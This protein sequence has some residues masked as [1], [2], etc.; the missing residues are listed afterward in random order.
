MCMCRSVCMWVQV[1]GSQ[2][3]L[4]QELRRAIVSSLAWGLGTDLQE[5]QA[6]P[7]LHTPF[8]FSLLLS[9]QSHRIT[10]RLWRYSPSQVWSDTVG[11]YLGVFWREWWT[12]V[13]IHLGEVERN[14]CVLGREGKLEEPW[15]KGVRHWGG[16][17]GDL[18]I[19]GCNLTK[20]RG[21]SVVFYE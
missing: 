4:Q 8:S 11:D 9:V 10:C 3:C 19:L 1:P 21:T 15:I 16:I 13:N 14:R 2:R 12:W 20:A 7:A 18:W 6:E 17:N 5:Q